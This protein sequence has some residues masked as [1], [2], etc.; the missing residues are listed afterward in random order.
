MIEEAQIREESCNWLRKQYPNRQFFLKP[1]V[2]H[3]LDGTL[4][5]YL[6]KKFKGTELTD[7]PY[8]NALPIRPDLIALV[9]IDKEKSVLWI[10]GECKASNVTSAALRQAK[11]Y[12]EA[13]H[14]YEGYVFYG[15]KLTKEVK[16]AVISGGHIYQGTNRWGKS[17]KKRLIFIKYENKQFTR[18]F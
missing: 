14:A 12:A 10:I 1:L 6:H 7:I 5:T 15:G 9:S 4:T 3:G 17:V 18:T 2:F 8:Y 16:E 13:T 11:Y